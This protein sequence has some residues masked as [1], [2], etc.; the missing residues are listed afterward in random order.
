MLEGGGTV[1]TTEAA[2]CSLF[3]QDDGNMNNPAKGTVYGLKVAAALI[4]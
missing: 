4:V 3:E 1:A 2:P